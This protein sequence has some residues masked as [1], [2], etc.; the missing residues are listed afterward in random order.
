MIEVLG[1][2]RDVDREH[3]LALSLRESEARFRAL[4]TQVVDYAIIGLDPD[5]VITSWNSGAERLKG[6]TAE[7]AVGQSFEIF[8]TSE[9]RS[10]GVPQQ[11]LVTARAEGRAECIGWRVRRD[12]TT[13]WADAVITALRHQ[14][15][16]LRG[17]AKVT[18]DMTDQ[19]RLE[20]A[21]ETLFATVTHDLRTPITAIQALAEVVSDPDTDTET[22]IQF[23]QRIHAR[24]EHLAKLVD[25]LARYANLRAGAVAITLEPLA[26]SALAS[27]CA[28][29]LRTLLEAHRLLVTDTSDDTVAMVDRTAM[30]RVLTNLLANAAKYSPAGSLITV[31]FEQHPTSV[32]VAV[33][34]RGRGIAPED[35]DTIFDD[36]TRGRLAQSDGG[37]GLG[38]ASVKRLVELQGG[39]VWVNSELGQ[40]TTVTVQLPR[41]PTTTLPAR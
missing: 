31:T 38:L 33:N 4:V 27:D 40:G 32:R 13:F 7:Q 34:D 35:L 3:R 1:V 14:D 36:F 5:G 22:R 21:Q 8:Y 19:H 28:L 37:T 24:I 6:Y 2:V 12:G 26:L 18:R 11:L 29:S 23:A 25:E 20:V 39:Q 17:F 9:D 15:G 16:T 10:A 30:D 41:A